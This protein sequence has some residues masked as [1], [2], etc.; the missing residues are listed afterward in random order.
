MI[1]MNHNKS[2]I[3]FYSVPMITRF[4]TELKYLFSIFYGSHQTRTEIVEKLFFHVDL[5]REKLTKCSTILVVSGATAT[6]APRKAR[7]VTAARRQRRHGP[8]TAGRRGGRRRRIGRRCHRFS[9]ICVLALLWHGFRFQK[10]KLG[11]D[12]LESNVGIA[13]LLCNFFEKRHHSKLLATDTLH[14]GQQPAC[15]VSGCACG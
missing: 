4:T 15:I 6:K 7:A 8:C 12:R 2:F 11:Q 5:Q 9:Q 1:S 3:L 14:H 13:L 10:L